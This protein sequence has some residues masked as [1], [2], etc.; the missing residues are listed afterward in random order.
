V[1]NRKQ[2]LFL[3]TFEKIRFILYNYI[4]RIIRAISSFRVIIRGLFVKSV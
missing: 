3:F 4:R 1:H 2:L